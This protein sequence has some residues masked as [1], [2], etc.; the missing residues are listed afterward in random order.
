MKKA[1][2]ITFLVLLVDQGSKFW[3]KTN[4]KIGDEFPVLGNWFL[5]HF[6]ENNGMAFGLELEGNYGK[7]LLSSFRIV[8]II[9]LAYYL[10]TLIKKNAPSLLIVCFSL[11]LGGAIGN[12]IDSAFYGVIFN[13]SFFEVAT[14]FPEEGGYAGYLHGRVVDMLYFPLIEGFFPGWVP[15]WGGEHFLFFRPVFNVADTAV[16]VGVAMLILFQKKL[17][18]EELPETKEEPIT[19]AQP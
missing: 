19:P 18:V 5:I 9:G 4:L 11:I 13:D 14:L 17:F 15:F 3:V 2:F 6:L 8:A 7:L 16:S 12:I 10:F 1:V